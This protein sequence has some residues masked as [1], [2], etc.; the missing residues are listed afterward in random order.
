MSPARTSRSRART[1]P[2]TTV[3][4]LG[5]AG[6]TSFFFEW[7]TLNQPD[8]HEVFYEGALIHDTGLVGDNINEGTG[9]A[10]V[11]VPAGASTQVTVTVTGPEAGTVWDYTVNCPAAP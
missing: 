7:E 11:V 3:H 1:R 9:S 2:T 8:Q 5:V 10:T 6:P 4:E